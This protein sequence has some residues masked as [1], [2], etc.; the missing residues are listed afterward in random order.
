MFVLYFWGNFSVEN[1]E[2]V[3][4]KWK[5]S[6]DEYDGFFKER[7]DY[8]VPYMAEEFGLTGTL[9]EVTL[10]VNDVEGGTILLNTT[11]PDLSKGSWTGKYYTDYPVTVTAVAA[12]GYEFAGWSGSV[13]S[14]NDTINVEVE[15]GGSV[16]EACFEKVTE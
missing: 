3:F 6:I 9:E 1:V 2:N 14:K 5:V 11:T 7:F 4:S 10:K 8:I 12:E 15:A 16:L 13:T